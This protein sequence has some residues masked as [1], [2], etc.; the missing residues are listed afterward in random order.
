MIW[1]TLSSSSTQDMHADYTHSNA[2]VFLFMLEDG[3]GSTEWTLYDGRVKIS[4]A[5]K[6]DVAIF[7]PSLCRRGMGTKAIYVS[8]HELIKL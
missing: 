3:N 5:N 2:L 6:G 8:I 4:D 1:L 7:S